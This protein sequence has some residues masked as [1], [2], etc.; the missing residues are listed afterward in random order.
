M[1][2]TNDHDVRWDTVETELTVGRV[3]Y[4]LT[5]IIAGLM[6]V[7]VLGDF[8]I[9]WAQGT[10]IVRVFALAVAMLVGLIGRALRVLLS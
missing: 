9:S 4:W 1:A 5:T 8:F 10:P 2:W 3:L 7:F 6:F